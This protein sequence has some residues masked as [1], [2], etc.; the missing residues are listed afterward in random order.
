M[1]LC[2]TCERTDGHLSHNRVYVCYECESAAASLFCE[3]CEQNICDTCDKKIHNKGARKKHV[4]AP[5]TSLPIEAAP[6]KSADPSP[7]DATE[8]ADPPQIE[9]TKREPAKASLPLLYD[10]KGKRLR[11]YE[12]SG[13]PPKKGSGTYTS[14]YSNSKSRNFARNTHSYHKS[15]SSTG[16][17]GKYHYYGSGGGYSKTSPSDSSN[18]HQERGQIYHIDHHQI[19]IPV[20]QP[21]LQVQKGQGHVQGQQ[22]TD[23][24]RVEFLVAQ[25]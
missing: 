1:P 8:P 11:S 5:T 14:P 9:E 21:F 10:T 20:F 2:Q 6:T 4:K 17:G 19:V 13:L 7:K 22:G 3:E 25:G 23:D 16:S 12:R 15:S 18:R 24:S